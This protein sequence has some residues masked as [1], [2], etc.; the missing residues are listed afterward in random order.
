M[1]ARTVTIIGG[2]GKIAL[3]L[4]KLLHEAGHQVTS[5]VRDPLQVPDVQEAGGGAVVNDIELMSPEAMADALAN[6]DVVVWSAGAGGGDPAR[7]EAVDHRAAVRSMDA[8]ATAG[9]NRYVMVSYFGSSPDHGVPQDNAFH[10][11][12]EAKAAA[13]E[14]LRASELDWVILG[15][16]TLTDEPGTGRISVGDD[17]DSGKVSRD[18][19]A[20]VAAY[21]ID[22][23]AVSRQTIRFNDGDTP[24]GQAI[25]VKDP[26]DPVG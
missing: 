6:T 5:W 13:D 21:V 25:T 17:Q 8:A 20:Q 12:A 2:H 3:R 15:P 14:A 22:T 11:Y 16:S 19:V 10:A 26:F 9:V 7:T 23:P 1:D 4:S 18:N 24:I